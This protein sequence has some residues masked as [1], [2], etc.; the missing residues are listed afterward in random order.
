ML[1]RAR[2]EVPSYT[3]LTKLILDA[4]KRQKQELAA[5]IE[6]TLREDTRR[7][8]DSLLAQ[9]P[10]EGGDTPGKTSA[11]KLTLM[12]KLSQST[13]PSKIEERVADLDLGEQQEVGGRFLRCFRISRD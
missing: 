2:I 4:I 10:L 1:V 8:L 9:E 13:K 7:L 11:Y 6:R 3:R 12:K 5:I